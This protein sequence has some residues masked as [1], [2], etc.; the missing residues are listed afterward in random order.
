MA[1][2]SGRCAAQN[3]EFGSWFDILLSEAVTQGLTGISSTAEGAG[4]R[5]AELTNTGVQEV[6]SRLLAS[7]QVVQRCMA[8]MMEMKA[9]IKVMKEKDKD[10]PKKSGIKTDDV[11]EAS[12]HTPERWEGTGAKVTFKEFSE[13][14]KNWADALSVHGVSLIEAVEMSRRTIEAGMVE[15]ACGIKDE[16]EAKAFFQEFDSRL[17]RMLKKYAIGEAGKYVQN[18]QRSGLVAWRSLTGRYDPQDA[19]GKTAAY[20]LISQPGKRAK[21]PIEARQVIKEWQTLVDDYERRYGMMDCQQ[22]ISITLSLLLVAAVDGIFRAKTWISFSAMMLEVNPWLDYRTTEEVSKSMKSRK[23]EES[24]M[25]LDI[26]SMTAKQKEEMIAALGGK[27][28][29]K[30]Y[31]GGKAGGYQKWKTE[32]Q[33][34]SSYQPKGGGKQGGKAEPKGRGKGGFKGECYTCGEYGHSARFC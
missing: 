17:Y 8:E 12:N 23:V 25:E 1:A 24:P 14:V 22:K 10:K 33:H 34:G 2:E 32:G 5:W 27:S 16:D 4:T 11:K 30:G 31:P 7:E 26:G 15:D 13:A 3:L 19:T 28:S 29:G 9:E 18:K 21:D 20:A 6:M